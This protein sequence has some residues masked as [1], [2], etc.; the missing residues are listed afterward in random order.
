[1]AQSGGRRE[2]G[3]SGGDPRAARC[4][5]GG[6]IRLYWWRGVPNLGDSVSARIVAGLSGRRVSAVERSDRRK[7]LAC[8]SVA[9]RAR[10]G[11]I[12]WGSGSIEP[13][14]PPSSGDIDVRAV[15]GPRTRAMLLAA[16]IACPEVYGDPALLL[17]AILPQRRAAPR[18]RLAIIPH[19]QD[20]PLVRSDDPAVR[21]LDVQGELE[22][23]LDELLACER[24]VSSSLHG[25]IFAE[26]YG[27]PAFELRL[28]DEVRG[29]EHK[30]RDYYEGSGRER[31]EPLSLATIAREPTWRAPALDPAF[32]ASFPF[33]PA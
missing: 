33:R 12:V 16:G 7:L 24:A 1:M 15:R 29:A 14:R 4:L 21:V 19:Y 6:A 25:L 28:G 30:F 13:D 26:A 18:H 3:G 11:D 31:P 20:K 17:P 27:I 9:H 32:A 2:A 23:F 10:A 22:G 8:G 5:E